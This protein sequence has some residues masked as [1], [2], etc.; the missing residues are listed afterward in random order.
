MFQNNPTVGDYW[1]PAVDGFT[2]PTAGI[3]IKTIPD[4]VDTIVLASDGYP[5]L[6]DN[7][8]ESESILQDNLLRDPLIF[9]EY[10]STKGMSNGDVSYDDRAFIK[11][12]LKR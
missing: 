5:V 7:L 2:I 4:D 10:K 6:K 9:R 11:V 12:N 1:Y 3:I 8:Q